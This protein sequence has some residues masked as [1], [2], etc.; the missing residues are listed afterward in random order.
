MTNYNTPRESGYGTAALV[1]GIL[2]IVFAVIIPFV[3]Y[4]ILIAGLIVV[5]VANHKG[6]PRVGRLKTG[7]LLLIIGLV[8]AVVNS[9]LG[10]IL[11][12]Q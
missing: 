12:V 11:A 2:S 9:I 5:L 4:L 10:A 3:A 1:M 6:V 7:R 8:V